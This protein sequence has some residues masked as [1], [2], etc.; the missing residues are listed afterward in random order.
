MPKG[1]YDRSRLPPRPGPGEGKRWATVDGR[2]TVIDWPPKPPPRPVA[3]QW[4][5]VF[6]PPPDGTAPT[7]NG[8]QWVATCEDRT[9]R[10]RAIGPATPVYRSEVMATGMVIENIESARWHVLSEKD[11]ETGT[12]IHIDHFKRVEDA[13]VAGTMFLEGAT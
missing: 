1:V 9:A 12:W 3:S 5:F 11:E 4:S 8:G 6:D 7:F 13:H 2:R 10:V